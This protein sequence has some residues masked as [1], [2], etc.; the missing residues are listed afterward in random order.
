MFDR[1][2]RDHPRTAGES[3]LAHQRVAMGLGLSLL[4]AGLASLVHAVIPGL[5]VRTASN[6]IQALNERLRARR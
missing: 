2:F 6:T 5:C 4:G 1:L 3:Y